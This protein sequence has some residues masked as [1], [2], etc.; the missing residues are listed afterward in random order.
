MQKKLLFLIL[1]ITIVVTPCFATGMPVIDVAAIAQAVQ[2]YVQQINQWQ[3]Q[4]KQWKSEFDRLQ[5]AAED[6]SNGDFTS[7]LTGIA[8]LSKQMSTW[9]LGSTIFNDKTL[10]KA[11]NA[12]GDGAY[13]LLAIMNDGELFSSY[14][15]Y[16]L[17]R[18]EQQVNKWSKD[19][20]KFDNKGNSASQAIGKTGATGSNTTEIANL[21]LDYIKKSLTTGGDVAVEM[22]N[23]INGFAEVFSIEPSEAAE[24]YKEIQEDKIKSA[25][26]NKAKNTKEIGSLIDSVSEEIASATMELAQL[27]SEEQKNAYEQAKLK[28]EQL[29]EK[30]QNYEK[31]LEWSRGMDEAIAKINNAQTDYEQAQEIK[32]AGK[33]AEE[34]GNNLSSSYVQA[35]QEQSIRVQS[36]FENIQSSFSVQGSSVK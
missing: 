30:K 17:K 27:N 22:A 8:S 7:I 13:S 12:T 23:A 31:L 15:N 3:T 18:I 29:N 34:T 5:K 36:D 35:S 9:N 1:I 25:T 16:W 10:D 21:V 14:S 26:S 33:L 6:L 4:L 19:W 24:M 11:L 32:N 20:E 2:T 28:L